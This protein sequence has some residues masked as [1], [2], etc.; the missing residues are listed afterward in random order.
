MSEVEEKVFFM[1]FCVL[2][3]HQ[4]QVLKKLFFHLWSG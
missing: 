1:H 4:N 2:S 3:D